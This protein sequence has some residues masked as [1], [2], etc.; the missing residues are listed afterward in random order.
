MGTS[1]VIARTEAGRALVEK[2]RP[3]AQVL[4][5]TRDQAQQIAL[6]EPAKQT[7]LRKLLFRDFA[8]K[9]ASGLCDIPLILKKY[10]G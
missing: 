8:Q 10:G 1:L 9:T 4:E 7:L 3:N 6:N 5:C 2:L